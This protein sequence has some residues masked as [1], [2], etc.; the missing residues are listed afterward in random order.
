MHRMTSTQARHT[1]RAVLQA[2][3]DASNRCYGIAP[4]LFSRADGEP[5]I[6][7][8]ARRAEAIRFCTG[9]PV[10]AACE[11]L[12]LRAGDGNTRVDDM[13]RGGRSGT[14]LAAA[15]TAQAERLTAA[16]AADRDT[17]GRQLDVLTV[18]LRTQA[19]TSPDGRCSGGRIHQDANRAE[20][21]RR[22]RVLA[23]QVRQIRTARRARAGWGVAA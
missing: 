11:E 3:V 7:W 15:R 19:S 14:E 13:V 18:K 9:C 10:R 5:Q 1:R 8:Q 23:D 6:T 2:A 4:D 22:I 12:A 16:A 17:E 21:N 20:Q